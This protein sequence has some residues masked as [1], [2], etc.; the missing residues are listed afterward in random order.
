MAE[1]LFPFAP[2]LATGLA[3]FLI[4]SGVREPRKYSW[5]FVTAGLAMLAAICY[6]LSDLASLGYMALV[7][8]LFIG[9][10]CACV[11]IIS[12]LW[13]TLTLKGWR[14]LSAI[15]LGVAFPLSMYYSILVGDTKSPESSTRHNGDVI[16]QALYQYQAGTGRFP[17]DL[18]DLEPTLL[19]TQPEALTTQGTGWLYESTSDSFTL[20]YWYWPDKFGSSVCLYES[21]NSQWNCAHNNWGPFQTVWTPGPCKNDQGEWVDS[22]KCK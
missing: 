19:A 5:L 9:F 2:L 3:S 6:W 11:A 18:A 8:A 21:S 13:I 4:H 10:L 15:L 17:T 16:V 7:G 14:K 1:I 22:A 20:G 12:A